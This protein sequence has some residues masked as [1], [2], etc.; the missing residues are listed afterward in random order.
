MT[1]VEYMTYISKWPPKR[2]NAYSFASDMHT[3]MILMSKHRVFFAQKNSSIINYD[4]NSIMA[5]KAIQWQ[6]K[7]K[8]KMAA[9]M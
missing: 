8:S 5:W 4:T 7:V 1:G 6:Y 3:I 2:I 9:T